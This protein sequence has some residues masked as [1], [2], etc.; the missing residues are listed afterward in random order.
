HNLSLQVLNSKETSDTFD[1]QWAV[2]SA[3]SEFITKLEEQTNAFR[4]DNIKQITPW[5]DHYSNLLQIIK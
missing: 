4:P 5:T 3:D 1:A 2:L